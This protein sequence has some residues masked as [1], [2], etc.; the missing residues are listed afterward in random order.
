M[1]S[2]LRGRMR[3][4]CRPET[5]S[6]RLVTFEDVHLRALEDAVP[7]CTDLG[8]LAATPVNAE[9]KPPEDP[10]VHG[11]ADPDPERLHQ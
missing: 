1:T 4:L 6:G 8:T 9:D 2:T 3:K 11:L 5:G 7:A 10:N